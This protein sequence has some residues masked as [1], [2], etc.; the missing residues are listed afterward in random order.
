MLACALAAILGLGGAPAQARRVVQ[1]P[2][3]AAAATP[4]EAFVQAR[5]AAL[6]NDLARFDAA[7]ARVGATP[8]REYLDYWRLRIRI[9]PARPEAGADADVAAFLERNAGTAVAE[10]MRRDWLASLGRRGEWPTFDAQFAQWGP[11]DDAQ[12]QCWAWMS[13]T[14][15][16]EPLPPDARDALMQPRELGEGCGAL[17]GA[18]CTAGAG[19]LDAGAWSST[20]I[21]PLS[22]TAA[23]SL[24][25]AGPGAGAGPCPLGAAAAVRARRS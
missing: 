7:A 23:P 18:S 1:R 16:G 2:A 4:D 25:R 10:Q 24:C 22:F 15:R 3:P 12:V 6:Q 13:A 8:L 11:R 14:Q 20:L 5:Q 19:P 9:A 17:V 21:R